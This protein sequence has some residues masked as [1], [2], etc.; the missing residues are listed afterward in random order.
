M[1]ATLEVAEH[2]HAA[3]MPDVERVGR[4][5]NPQICSYLLLLEQFVRAW[6]H[7]VNHATP[8]EFLY[9]IFHLCVI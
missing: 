1:S 4:W 5:V 9:K 3:E 6:H 7:L 8:S 2:H